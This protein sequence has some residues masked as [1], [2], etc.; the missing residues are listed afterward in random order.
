MCASGMEGSLVER[1][2]R[3]QAVDAAES[4]MAE[5][6]RESG[7]RPSFVACHTEERR[8]LEDLRKGMFDCK[9]E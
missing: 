5:A 1:A 3:A 4:E 2:A 8:V 6:R 7:R 9:L